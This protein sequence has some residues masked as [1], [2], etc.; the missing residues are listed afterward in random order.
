MP[1]PH[2]RM[3]SFLWNRKEESSSKIDNP[4][5][6]YPGNTKSSFIRLHFLPVPLPSSILNGID[7]GPPAPYTVAINS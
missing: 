1:F 3:A 7:T 4:T 5:I 2:R 6:Y